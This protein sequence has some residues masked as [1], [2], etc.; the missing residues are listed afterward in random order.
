MWQLSKR[1]LIIVTAPF[2]FIGAWFLY[3]GFTAE[4]DMYTGS[5]LSNFYYMMGG[6][7]IIL[8]LV[9][10][11]VIFLVIKKI[12]TR[13]IYLA[14]NGIRGEAEILSLEQTGIYI[15]NLPQIRFQLQVNLPN[16]DPYQIEHKETVNLISLNSLNIGAKF[17]VFVDPVNPEKVL[18]LFNSRLEF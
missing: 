12:N 15:N 11:G 17:P 10:A 13:K 5:T 16:R 4:P 6:M 14:Q 8:P 3:S 7:F 2:L 9:L 18:L 1:I